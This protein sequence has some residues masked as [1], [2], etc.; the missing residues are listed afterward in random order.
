MGKKDLF[1]ICTEKEFDDDRFVQIQHE[2]GTNL[3][4]PNVDEKEIENTR[5]ASNSCNVTEDGRAGTAESS[6]NVT[7]D[8]S[9]R[10]LHVIELEEAGQNVAG[11]RDDE[12]E[13]IEMGQ[14]EANMNTRAREVGERVNSAD[15]SKCIETRN[16]FVILQNET[17]ASKQVNRCPEA[18][19]NSCDT[20][21]EI[22]DVTGTDAEFLESS[23]DKEPHAHVGDESMTSSSFDLQITYNTKLTEANYGNEAEEET[24]FSSKQQFLRQRWM[25]GYGGSV[26]T[27]VTSSSD[28]DCVGACCVGFVGDGCA[29]VLSAGRESECASV[30]RAM[31]MTAFRETMTEGNRVMRSLLD[32]S[33]K[34]AMIYY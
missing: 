14:G 9:K 6:R 17:S 30:T 25:F 7:D 20:D 8:R 16:L 32:G 28:V 29:C 15:E 13:L 18:I 3:D 4:A 34:V 33:L 5:S 1:D 23:V 10:P 2:L 22:D 27:V 21:A 12:D 19:L 24:S 31:K 26:D 11:E